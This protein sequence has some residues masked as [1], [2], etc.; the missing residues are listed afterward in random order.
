M[1]TLG[2][3]AL[4]LLGLS[5]ACGAAPDGSS[6]SRVV[7]QASGGLKYPTCTAGPADPGK[8]GVALEIHV[9]NSLL[10]TAAETDY[11]LQIAQVA[12]DAGV[13]LSFGLGHELLD[14][15]AAGAVVTTAEHGDQ[16]LSSLVALLQDTYCHEVTLH[17]DLPDLAYLPARTYLRG[18]TAELSAAGANGTVASGVCTENAVNGGWLRAARD[19]GIRTIAGVVRDCQ[20]TLD[21]DAFPAYT[22][23]PDACSPALCHEASPV[24]N[25]AQRASGW[26]ARSVT[27][28]IAPFTPDPGLELRN[29]VFIVGSFGEANVPCLAEWAAGQDVGT[30]CN[31]TGLRSTDHVPDDDYSTYDEGVD[32]A[33][34]Y[35]SELVDV[36]DHY[37]SGTDGDAFHRAFSTNLVVTGDWLEGF[38]GTVAAG[39]AERTAGDGTPLSDHAAFTTLGTL[40]R[41]N[42]A[43][44]RPL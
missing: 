21:A 4:V 13:T 15:Y 35:L 27:D 1:R 18:Y 8:L 43:E 11:V 32:D 31:D 22:V 41:P 12:A 25:P 30:E 9:E 39:V 23:L 44:L 36:V 20:V 17:A 33:D 10:S 26:F 29:S 40:R 2:H 38:F 3:P 34:V 37:R 5:A 28:W 6:A 42:A 19:A 7:A 24:D 14:D 16:T